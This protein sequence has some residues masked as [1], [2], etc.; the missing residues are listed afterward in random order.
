MSVDRSGTVHIVWPTVLNNPEPEG[1]LFYAMTRDGNTFTT[2]VRIPT[3]GSPKPS[4]P[5][6]AVDSQGDVLIAWDEVLQGTRRAFVR[7]ATNRGGKIE[8][9]PLIALDGDGPSM[10]PVIAASEGG[11]IVVWTAGAQGSSVIRIRRL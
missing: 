2:R 8:F 3:H 1:A 5:Q 9:G 6:V 4:H 7:S 10:Y 11:A